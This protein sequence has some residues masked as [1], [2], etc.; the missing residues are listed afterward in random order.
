MSSD[1]S[2]AEQRSN[3]RGPGVDWRWALPVGR[4]LTLVVLVVTALI[5]AAPEHR[6]AVGGALLVCLAGSAYGLQ[7]GPEKWRQRLVGLCGLAAGGIALVAID[8]SAPGWLAGGVA[9]VAGLV[10]LPQRPALLFAALAAVGLTTAPLVRGDVGAVPI[11]AAVCGGCAVLGMILGGV[12]T[13]AETAERLLVVEQSARRAAAETD[14]YAERQ[15]LARE[16]HDIIAHT[17]SAQTVQLEGARLLLA[18]GAPADAIRQHIEAAQRLARDGLEETRRAVHSLRGETRPL[19]ETIRA[20]ADTAGATYRQEG[21]ARPM[22]PGAALA[23]ERT[24]QEALTN[25]R[26]HA[27]GAKATVTMRFLG[28]RDEVE[29]CDT[30]PAEAAGL[31]GGIFGSGGHGLAGMRERAALIGAELTTGPHPVEPDGRGFRVWLTAPRI[32]P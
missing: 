1:D 17:L 6:L 8:S 5:V 27:P 21:D 20:L 11:L 15:R 13:R 32:E 18:R 9:I 26:K 2:P 14:R 28:D 29:I 3:A 4:V 25:V 31:V 12:R 23:I 30:G 22:R 24:V 16:I 10:R 7:F 19:A